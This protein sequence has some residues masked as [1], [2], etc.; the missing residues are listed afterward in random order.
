[1]RKKILLISVLGICVLGT[2]ALLSQTMYLPEV[3]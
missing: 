1:M 2:V 3:I